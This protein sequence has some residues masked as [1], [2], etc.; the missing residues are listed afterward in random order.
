[1]IRFCVS[2]RTR[3]PAVDLIRFYRGEDGSLLLGKGKR[4][5]WVCPT[6]KC[7]HKL[8]K[9]PNIAQRSLQ[10]KNIVANSCI[11]QMQDWN[12]YIISKYLSL[13]QQSGVVFSG[14]SQILKNKEILSFLILCSS[15][16]ASRYIAEPFTHFPSTIQTFYL[17]VDPPTLG[18]WIGKRSRNSVGLSQNRHSSQLLKYL[19]QYK[20]LR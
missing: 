10:S 3:K 16:I 18:S 2:C 7:I 12:K 8:T 1:V 6:K 17:D 15:S 9:K 11:Q 19:H 14:R 5:A 13:S 4:S 20:D